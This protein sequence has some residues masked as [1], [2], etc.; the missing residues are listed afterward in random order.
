[1]PSSRVM[2]VGSINADV[3]FEVRR[4]PV[5]GET[6]IADAV[7]RSSGGKGA[8]QAHAAARSSKDVHVAMAGA[9]G[10]DAVGAQMR[11][12]LAC[13][14]V[15]VS[16]IREVD[17]VSG[18]AMIAVDS[19]GGNVIVVAPGANNAWPAEPYVPIDAGDI[20]ALQ[21]ELPLAVVEHVADTA[22][23]RGAR[24]VLNAA[25]VTPGAARLLPLVDTLIVNEGEASD[26]LGLTDFSP[27]AVAEVAARHDLNLV[28]TLGR[29]GAVLSPRGGVPSRVPII[30]VNTVDTVGAGDA[31]VGAL[32]AALAAGDDLLSAARRGA[33]AGALTVTARGAR[34]PEL[35][36]DVID[37]LLRRHP[38]HDADQR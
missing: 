18:M 13:A 23:A 28:V 14:G 10:Q 8:N 4:I 32:A 38:L 25:P 33:A 16:L 19:E 26:L 24:V 5:V 20:V 2:V 27:D 21:L 36:A 15:D 22:H 17:E 31:F 37:E 12:E 34:H 9:V 11:D 7:H 1:M 3:T 6:I 29:Q 30:A 35:S